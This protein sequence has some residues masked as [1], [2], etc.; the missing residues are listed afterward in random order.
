MSFLH[1]ALPRSKVLAAIAALF[2]AAF[3]A[4]L[5][6]SPTNSAAEEDKGPAK[7]P[8]EKAKD[9]AEKT[10]RKPNGETTRSLRDP[11]DA[12]ITLTPAEGSAQRVVNIDA[13]RHHEVLRG[14]RLEADER[15][16]DR[17]TPR[18]LELYADPLARTGDE[19]LESIAFPE[20][21][22]SEPRFLSNRRRIEFAVCLDPDDVPAGSYQSLVTIGGPD[23][24]NGTSVALT[25]N[26]KE[27]WPW[28]WAGLVV[29][30]LAAGATLV[31]TGT[32]E[33]RAQLKRP[34]SKDW[35]RWRDALK[36]TYKDPQ[37][38]FTSAIALVTAFGA[39]VGTYLAD[40]TW[41]AS[42]LTGVSGLVVAAFASV[43]G[44]TLLAGLRQGTRQ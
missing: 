34:E 3:V 39:V 30:L 12:E 36:E 23:G 40:P 42:P 10:C 35:P 11:L 19:A 4:A 9:R 25:A 26:A 21:K 33:M 13:D 22:F 6:V 27:G 43:G 32:A 7:D 1:W 41:G 38:V 31:F 8:A 2:T 18:H 24:V 17:V 16:P 15:M 20:L 29:A 44:Q 5:L 28:F 37:W 14:I